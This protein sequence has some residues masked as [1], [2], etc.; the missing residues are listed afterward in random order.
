LY[1][2][3]EWDIGATIVIAPE[4]R[5]DTDKVPSQ[6]ENARKRQDRAKEIVV[7]QGNG[8]YGDESSPVKHVARV[9]Q[10]MEGRQPISMVRSAE[11][12]RQLGHCKYPPL[13]LLLGMYAVETVRDRLRCVIEE[14]E[15]WKHLNFPAD[16]ETIGDE[17]G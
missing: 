14:I 13:R 5:D 9:A 16:D 8:V 10:W 7:D 4:M 6:G 3:S 17:E 12:M 11:L 15:D 2:V 1:E